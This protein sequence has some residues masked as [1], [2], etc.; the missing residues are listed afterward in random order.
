M[1]IV[2]QG[3]AIKSKNSMMTQMFECRKKTSSIKLNEFLLA[4]SSSKDIQHAT[5]CIKKLYVQILIG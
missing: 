4:F 2:Q 3:A 1:T 5:I